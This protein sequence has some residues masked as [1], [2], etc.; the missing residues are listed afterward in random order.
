MAAPQTKRRRRPD[1]LPGG[2]H[3]LSRSDVE[4]SQR[5]RI[6]AAVIDAVAEDGYQNA[7]VTDVIARAGVSRKTFYEHFRDKEECFLAAYDRMLGLLTKVTTEAYESETEWPDKVQAGAAAFIDALASH[8][9]AARACMV[10]VLAAGPRAL[11]RREAAVRGFTYFLDAG[12]AEAPRGLPSYSALAV[13]GGLNEILYTEILR[14]SP[15]R[16]RELVPDITYLLTLPFIGHE[17][18]QA[19]REKAA[20]ARAAELTA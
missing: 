19:Q 9:A 1:Q 12:R 3:G 18:A 13:L 17:R 8:P 4:R 14:G 11:A 7:R 5:G 16:L 10:E 20:A 6:L 15:A 2:R